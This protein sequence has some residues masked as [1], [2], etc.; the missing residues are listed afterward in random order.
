MAELAYRLVATPASEPTA[1]VIFLHGVFGRG[2][3]FGTLARRLV[4]ARR[5]LAAVLVDLRLH[6]DTAPTA[7]PHTL[8]AAAADLDSVVA[9]TS[10]RRVVAV[11]GHSLG[12]KV[13]L[14]FARAHPGSGRRT[15]ILDITPGA[16]PEALRDEASRSAPLR[17]L[18][19]LRALA[20]RRFADR[21]DFV[22]AL[23][24]AG[25]S[26]T[27]A[28]WLATNLE[29]ADEGGYRLGMDLAG[30]EQLLTDHYKTDLWPV[31]R[32]A[33]CRFLL[34]GRSEAGG[35]RDRSLLLGDSATDV[36]VLPEADHWLHREQPE[37]VLAWLL[38]K[39]P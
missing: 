30:I 13:A 36:Q 37:A 9:A 39:L 15:L 16:R 33:D 28:R 35:A 24:T 25:Q 27:T 11:I 18:Q 14:A 12:G 17:V 29:R 21:Q 2:R 20:P 26:V 19:Q 8:D 3:N 1:A 4:D 22:D 32:E 6:G 38:R 7:G 10:P 31:A 5:D 34:A 23:M